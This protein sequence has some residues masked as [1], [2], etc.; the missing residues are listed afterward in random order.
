MTTLTIVA[1]LTAK[2]GMEVAL[3]AAPIKLVEETLDEPGSLR[4]ELHQSLDVFSP[5]WSNVKAPRVTLRGTLGYW[6][7]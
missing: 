1:I 5:M 6:I 7:P 3:R 4:Y 2:A